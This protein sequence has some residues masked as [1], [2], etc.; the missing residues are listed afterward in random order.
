VS[1]Y[2]HPHIIFHFGK[3]EVIFTAFIS[4]FPTT[5]LLLFFFA[6]SFF[7][8]GLFLR[9]TLEAVEKGGGGKDKDNV[10]G[11]E[12]GVLTRT[13]CRPQEDR[14]AEVEE[15]VGG[16]DCSSDVEIDIKGE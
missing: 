9:L 8:L 3:K 10:E 14:E 2:L 7:S 16:T 13:C 4:F 11:K 6:G 15:I 5:V 1:K 12:C